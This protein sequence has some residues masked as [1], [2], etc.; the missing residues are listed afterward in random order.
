MGIVNNFNKSTN[1]ANSLMEQCQLCGRISTQPANTAEFTLIANFD[2]GIEC[3]Q[4]LPRQNICLLQGIILILLQVLASDLS[5]VFCSLG[6]LRMFQ[7]PTSVSWSSWIVC[8][9]KPPLALFHCF[10]NGSVVV[11]WSAILAWSDKVITASGSKHLAKSMSI[12][13]VSLKKSFSSLFPI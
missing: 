6:F 11:W 10:A 7:M 13:V 3:I 9:C 2:S 8:L 12:A 1:L 4:S 5:L